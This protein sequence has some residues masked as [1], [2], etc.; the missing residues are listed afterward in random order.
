[1]TARTSRSARQFRQLWFTPAHPRVR[2]EER[3]VYRS[4][5]LIIQRKRIQ[6]LYVRVK[7]EDAHV[8]ISA[9]LTLPRADIL[10]FVSSRWE[11]IERT[12]AKVLMN[13]QSPLFS[14]SNPHQWTAEH[15]QRAKEQ[16]EERIARLLPVWAARVGQ[17]PTSISYRAMTSRW[18]SCTPDTGRI[19]LN[20]AL[21]EMPEEFTQYVLVHE[22][23]HL[24]EH[25]HGPR[26]R[27]RMDQYLPG[28][29]KLRHAINQ[30]V[31]A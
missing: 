8:Q 2:S 31:I 7:G 20:L 6:N 30:Y 21:A 14:V 23:T 19:R 10:R 11:W 29:R 5:P 9:P 16:M 15:R 26:F 3:L 13:E 12:R 27:A 18:G 22:L 4:V 17:A 24:W 25:G 1:M 28:W